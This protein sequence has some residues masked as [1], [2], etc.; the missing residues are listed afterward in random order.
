MR[1]LVLA[2]L[3]ASAAMAVPAA[4]QTVTGTVNISGSVPSKCTVTNGTSAIA[5]GATVDMGDLSDTDATLLPTGTLE[6]RFSTTGVTAGS[7]SARVVCTTADA[8]I[9]VAATEL[10]TGGSPPTGYANTVHYKAD[11]AVTKVGSSQTY[12]D[13]TV[14]GGGAATALGAR[15]DAT[16]ANNVVISTSNWRTSTANDEVLFQGAYTGQIVVTIAPL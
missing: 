13:D 5:F 15:L 2:A 14:T 7:L 10:T 8:N 6:T 3:A 1:K 12:S 9:T 11:V 16:V 4:A